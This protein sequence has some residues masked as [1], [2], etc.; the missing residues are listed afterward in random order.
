MYA[1]SS[2]FRY[3]LGRKNSSKYTF[4]YKELLITGS[5]F[6]LSG[7]FLAVVCTVKP[8]EQSRKK[9]GAKKF[10]ILHYIMPPVWTIVIDKGNLIFLHNRHIFVICCCIA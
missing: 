6:P 2:I 7:F 10:P 1:S 4:V 3:A 5:E 8:W 9:I